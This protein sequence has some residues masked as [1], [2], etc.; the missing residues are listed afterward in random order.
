M[1]NYAAIDVGSNQVL[2]Y[3]VTLDNGKI[4]GE[5]LDRGV[6]TRLGEN[7]A[8]KGLLEQEAMNRTLSVLK[9]FKK[10]IDENNVKSVAAVGTAALRQSKNSKTFLGQVKKNTGISISIISGEE[11]AR[12]AFLAVS[13]SLD[14]G[15][16]DTV[17]LDIGGASTEFLHSRGN[18]VID[19][20][21]LNTGALILTEKY[22]KSDPVKDTELSAMEQSLGQCLERDLKRISQPFKDPLLAGIGG[23]MSTISAVK[24]QIE[25][26]DPVI[27][28]GTKIGINEI[29][30]LISS[31]KAKTISERKKI[32]GLQPERAG[33]ILAGTVILRSVMKIL[34]IDTIVVSDKGLR[35]ALIY[36]RFLTG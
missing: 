7:V 8:E 33:L 25:K 20:F 14:L 26:Y 13:R 34:C 9:S 2:I 24:H 36:D 30:T 23:T 5:V 19:L 12:L 29:N 32:I 1:K 11:E 21:S 31:L 16:T 35:H 17:I 4:S 22:L 10:L 28:H 3:I 15:N 27:V 6:V 18:D